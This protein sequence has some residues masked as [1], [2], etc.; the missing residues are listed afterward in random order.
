M[1]EAALYVWRHPRP[2]GADG[3]CI[4]RCDLPVD[5]RKAR[6]LARRIARFAHRHGLLHVV[7]T[8]PLRRSADVGRWL[9][10]WGWEHRIDASV[11]EL[12][13]GAWEGQRWDDIPRAEIDAWCADFVDHRPGGGEPL[14]ALLARVA[15]WSAGDAAIVVGH[16]G[17]IQAQRWRCDHGD[18]LPTAAEWPS[19]EPYARRPV[20][21]TLALT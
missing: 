21:F 9:R 7:I 18:R 15:V 5:P 12:D 8:S 13:F 11:I 1:S 19:P 14:R 4:G 2:V 10:R 17:W 6:R 3:R 16:A 20:A